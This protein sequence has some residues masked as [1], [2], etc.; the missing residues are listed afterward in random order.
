VTA[1]H[2]PANETWIGHCDC[3]CEPAMAMAPGSNNISYKEGGGVRTGRQLQE[4]PDSDSR[5]SMGTLS[6]I[7]PNRMTNHHH[8]VETNRQPSS[9]SALNKSILPPPKKRHHHVTTPPHPVQQQT[10]RV[11]YME[12]K[13]NKGDRGGSLTSRISTLSP[14]TKRKMLGYAAD[15]ILLLMPSSIFH[16]FHAYN[17]SQV[18]LCDD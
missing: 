4:V 11:I 7:D 1:I 16:L 14:G 13:E 3:K 5:S 6:A 2:L 10:S 18:I 8:H 9:W 15:G 12:C 17:L